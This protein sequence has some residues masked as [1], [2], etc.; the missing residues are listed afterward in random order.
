MQPTD[1]RSLLMTYTVFH[2][3]TYISL[4]AAILA[5]Q[6]I[7]LG[8]GVVMRLSIAL[9]VLASVCGAIVASHLPDSNSWE[10]YERMKIG[11]FGLRFARYQFWTKAEHLCVWIALLVPLALANFCPRALKW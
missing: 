3:G 9:L 1:N 4:T 7:G 11:P 5:A 10:H 2:I 6:T 8:L